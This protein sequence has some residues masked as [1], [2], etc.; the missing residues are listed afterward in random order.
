MI[1]SAM[2]D[3]VVS[4]LWIYRELHDFIA[5]LSGFITYGALPF[6]LAVM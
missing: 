1:Q 3:A 2:T 6:T 5:M 4:F